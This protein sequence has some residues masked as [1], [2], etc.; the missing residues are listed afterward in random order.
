MNRLRLLFPVL[1]LAVL[2]YVG[3]PLAQAKDDWLP[4]TPEDLAMKDSPSNPGAKAMIL[5]R[6]IDR[7]DQM[8]SQH[9]Y[10]RIKIFTEDGKSYADVSI[11]PFDREFKIS[12]VQGRTIHPD[13]SIVPFSGQVFEKVVE[14]SKDYK[15][16]A[17]SFT[18][19]DVTPGSII[20]YRY[21][22]Y[23]EAI[24]PATRIYYY[25]PQSEWEIS[26]PLF[27]KAAH[28]T[29]KPANPELFSYRMQA[30]RLPEG[31][32]FTPDK[33]RGTVNLELA[34]IPPFES[35]PYMPPD[36]EVEMRVLFFY[37]TDL[38]LPEGD[39]YWKQNGKKWANGAEGF[40]DKK[41][42]LSGAVASV[43]LPSDSPEVKLHKLYDFVQSFQNLSFEREKSAKESQALNIREVNNVADV[44]ANKYGYRSQLNR[45]FVA[46]ARSAGFEA[47]LVKITER[48]EAIL[49]REWPSFSQLGPEIAMVKLNGKNLFLDP[50]SLYCPFG[51]LPWQDTGVTGLVLAKTIPTWI[52]TPIPD[53]Q[54]ASMNRVAK[55]TLG[56]DGSL[57]GDVEL[58]FSGLYAY[59]RRFRAH[60]EDDTERKKLME[61]FLQRWIAIKGDIEFLGVNDWKASNAP[62]IAKYKVTLPGYASQAGRR[63]L[64][65]ATLFAGSYRNP[66]PATK[67]TNPIFMEYLFDDKDDVTITV[68]KA[69]QVES[70]PKQLND[71]NPV[72]E[73]STSYTNQNGELHFTREFLFKSIG[74][75]QKYYGALRAY[76][77]TVQA[78]A[79]EQAVLKTTA[80]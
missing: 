18:M 17:K 24:N 4:I 59:Q 16:S 40:M 78:G 10:V 19:P 68:P 21:T 1:F 27:Q 9:E 69:W 20:E 34:N 11:P 5:Y 67:R 54:D 52:T 51:I 3:S 57:S 45:T 42:V 28:F 53:P 66:F 55:M 35:E 30:T 41:G 49:H 50:G 36:S 14:R 73:M 72:A 22:R 23:W 71:R 63:V 58:T 6:S 38:R 76:F 13:G 61:E 8:G 26:G 79:N 31:A 39:E 44:I 2:F 56:D 65:P 70:L 32:K 47:T 7:D 25:F 37:S 64:L 33:L 43:T 15:I 74:L 46:L 77:Q 60:D 80:Q 12:G 62:L 75:E 29:F 48:D